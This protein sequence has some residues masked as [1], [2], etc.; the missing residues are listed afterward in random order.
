VLKERLAGH[1][2]A[3]YSQDRL[4]VGYLTATLGLPAD[5]LDAKT[6][7]V[8]LAFRKEDPM[9]AMM[10]LF[11]AAL[12]KQSNLLE[13]MNE[14]AGSTRMTSDVIELGLAYLLA[15]RTGTLDTIH[16]TPENLDMTQRKVIGARDRAR[17]QAMRQVSQEKA[18][19]GRPFR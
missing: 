1:A 2:C 8:V 4:V 11:E 18:T 9:L 5:E 15:E 10:G 6:Q 16:S 17:N 19:K 12:N 13:R 3:D 7:E 14:A